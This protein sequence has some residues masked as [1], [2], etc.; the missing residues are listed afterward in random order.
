VP[1]PQVVVSGHEQ[2][3]RQ[4]QA[5]AEER[6]DGPAPSKLGGLDFFLAFLGRDPQE[7]HEWLPATETVSTQDGRSPG[8]TRCA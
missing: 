8:S 7:R 6:I 1:E 2:G 4:Q 3:N 5:H